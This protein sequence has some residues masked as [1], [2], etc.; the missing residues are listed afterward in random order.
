MSV[1]V[2]EDNDQVRASIV[3]MLEALGYSSCARGSA[4][5]LADLLEVKTPSLL[6]VDVLLGRSDGIA[7]ANQVLAVHSGLPVIAIS[8]VDYAARLEQ[9]KNTDSALFLHKPFGLEELDRALK[10]LL[11]PCSPPP[12]S[13]LP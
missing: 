5:E 6:I 7:L 1:L 10:K 4:D 9:F 13:G 3:A 11:N 12:Q 8:G 2:L